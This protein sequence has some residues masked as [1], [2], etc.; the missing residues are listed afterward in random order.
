MKDRLVPLGEAGILYGSSVTV[1]Y[2]DFFM[3]Q[4]QQAVATE[5]RSSAAS[6]MY[7]R[8]FVRTYV[9]MYVRTYQTLIHNPER[10]RLLSISYSCFCLKKKITAFKTHLVPDILLPFALVAILLSCYVPFCS[11]NLPL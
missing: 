8:Q 3:M 6:N 10:M 9:R 5:E 11:I 4:Q 1:G 7:K 2:I